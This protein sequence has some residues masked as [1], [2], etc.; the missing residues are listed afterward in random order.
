LTCCLAGILLSA[1][2][3]L[4]V[5]NFSGSK[6]LKIMPIGDSITDDCSLNGAWR[7][8]LQPLLESNNYP[9]IFVGRQSSSAAPPSFTKVNHEGYCGAVIAPPGVY[10]VHGYSTVNAYLLKIVADALAVTN[11]HPDLVLL[12][13]GANDIGRGRDPYQVATHD[14]AQLIDLIL[15]NVPAANVILA[16]ITSLQSANLTG[17]NYADY[18]TNVPIYNAALQSTVNQRRAAGQNVF[19]ADMF[20]AVDYNTMFQSDHVHPNATGLKA[21]A[22]EWLTRIRAITV[23]TNQILSMLVHGGQAWRYSDSG[24]DLGA[25]WSQVGY[26]DGGWNSG[27]A[28]LGYGD[29]TLATDIGFGPD[30]TNKYIT[31]YFR[32][33]FEVPW[34]VTLTNLNVRLAH[35]GGAVVWLNGQELLR[36]NLPSGP[37]TY[38]NLATRIMVGYTPQ[39]FYPVNIPISGLPSG[40]NWL[41]VEIHQNF[42]T[43]TLLGFDFELFGSGY[44]QPRPSLG[45]AAS[46]DGL[47]L[48]W[49]VPAGDSLG[50]YWSTGLTA[51]ATWSRASGS[52]ETNGDRVIFNQPP[53]VSLKF[54]RLQPQ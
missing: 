2:G 33:E 12:L 13:I 44:L 15:T 54:F 18:A 40:T 4:I 47:S 14:M 48:S 11:N 30:P 27:L 29:S 41:A 17:F 39:V 52:P 25:T 10:A 6:P 43:S 7:L 16:K 23:P 50:L 21:M 53:D 51:N 9:F 20:S 32:H 35:T 3:E 46:A 28:R 45:I 22:N 31:T 5:T 19:L 38:T 49:P 37:I 1:K 36:T 42:H 26:E 34:N 24:Q 8:Y